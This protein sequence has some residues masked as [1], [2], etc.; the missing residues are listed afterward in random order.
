MELKPVKF[1]DA[2]DWMPLLWYNSGGTRAKR[3]LQDLEGN[4]WFFKCSERKAAKDGKPEKYYKYEFWSE[5]IAFQLGQHLGLDILEYQPALH[6]GEVGCI[7]PLMI[8][9]WEEELLE[10]GR[11]MTAINENFLPENVKSRMEYTF[12]LLTD[13]LETF[14]LTSYLPNILET[15]IFDA[16]IG[17]TDRHQENWAFIGKTSFFGE[18]IR[19]IEKEVKK[20]GFKKMNWLLRKTYNRLFDPEKNEL[21]PLGQQVTLYLKKIVKMAPIYDSGSSLARELNEDRINRFLV[22]NQE[23]TKYIEKGTT[24]LHWEKTKISHFTFLQNLLDSS[25]L[26]QVKLAGKFLDNYKDT[27]VEEMISS[28]DEGVPENYKDIRIPQ[29]RKIL[30][31]K[32]VNLR[33]IRVKELIYDGI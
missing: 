20:K 19:E 33:V 27:W 16:V 3:V 15:L 1:I 7:S 6:N 2:T 8:K 28:V 10:I 18:G 32:L 29:N 30:M 11:Y 5:V 25:Y 9:P 4:E 26:E 17:N 23:L 21:S 14:D 13:T 24:E 22:D 12:E 31:K